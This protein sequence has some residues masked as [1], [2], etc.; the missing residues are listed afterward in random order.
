MDYHR[1]RNVKL[2]SEENPNLK[3]KEILYCRRYKYVWMWNRI[4][5]VI[6]DDN[7]HDV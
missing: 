1:N 7:T 3:N 2:V 5:M 4:R 6:M